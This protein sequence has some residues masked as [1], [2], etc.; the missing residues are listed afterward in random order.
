MYSQRGLYYFY[1]RFLGKDEVSCG[2]LRTFSR[3]ISQPLQGRANRRIRASLWNVSRGRLRF[4][5]DSFRWIRG[6]KLLQI[7][8]EIFLFTKTAIC[9]LITSFSGVD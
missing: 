7:D 3:N 9:N 6:T 2:Q 8:R 1:T 5:R 4:R